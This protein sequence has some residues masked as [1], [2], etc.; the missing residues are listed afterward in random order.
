MIINCIDI[1]AGQTVQ[2]IG[3]REKALDAGAPQDW[4]ARFAPMG[5]VAVVDLDAALS[6]GDNS[7]TIEALCQ[8]ARCR[9]GGGIRSV[10]A[11][12]RWLDA[13]AA[14]V[15]LGTAATTSVVSKLPRDRVIAALDAVN[16]EVVVEGWRSKTG[17]RI[18]ARMD[19]L[20]PH[21]SGFLVTFVER[22][23]RMGGIDLERVK[24]LAEAAGDARLTVAGG[25]TTA[26]EIAA[27]DAM[28]VDAQVGMAIY[29]GA[30]DWLD[31]FAAPLQSDRADGL[32]PTVVCDVYDRALGLCWSDKE[33]LRRAIET[34]RGVYRSRSRGLWVKGETSG[35]TQRLLRVD[36]DCDRDAL[37]FTVAQ[38]APGFCHEGSMSCWGPLSGL[39]GLAATLTDR[40]KNAPPASYTKKLLDDPVL[41]RNKLLEEAAELAE[42]RTPDDVA[43]EAADV[44]YF[45]WVALARAGVPLDA[46]SREL[47][48]R[49]SS[50]TR[51][52]QP[53]PQPLAKEKV[54]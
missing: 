17:Q 7:A 48:R 9:V 50:V 45:T 34:R 23:G 24:Q 28:G 26:S 3:G 31:A 5:E 19:E 38:Q 15:V 8:T 52:S 14:R 39:P 20:R 10:D 1:M 27:L 35:A 40:A 53:P 41:L 13:G 47:D 22:E 4:A 43:W 12:R 37:R 51:R 33:S 6:Q 36:V 21:V 16:G 42:A 11:A 46:V 2:L 25:I 18:E 29:T 44:I 49:T 54:A 30:L 32:W